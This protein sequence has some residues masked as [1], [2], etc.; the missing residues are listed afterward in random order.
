[1][2]VL[3]FTTGNYGEAHNTCWISAEGE[4]YIIGVIWRILLYYA[5]WIGVTFIITIMHVRIF[6][7]LKSNIDI[8][9]SESVSEYTEQ[10]MERLK[11]F[12][13]INVV[14][15]L[16]TLVNTL[17]DLIHSGGPSFVLSIIVTLP[18]SLLGITHAIMFARTPSVKIIL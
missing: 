12:P 15:V 10:I 1:M 4:G 13:I 8:N 14:V 2:V 7:D 18:W 16:P 17:Y 11:L 9:T 5:P 6:R 3:P